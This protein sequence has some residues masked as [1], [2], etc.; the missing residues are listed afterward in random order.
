MAKFYDHIDPKVHA[1]IDRQHIFFTA[2]AAEGS[3][4]N[5]SPKGLDGFRVLDTKTVAY[6]DW[7]GS[8]NETAAHIRADGRL[9]IMMCAF[10]GPPNILRLYGRGR[11]LP[12]SSDAFREMIDSSFD[13]EE[14]ASARQ[15]IVLDVESVQTSC[16]FGVP[17]YDYQGERASLARWAE[18]ASDLPGYRAGNNLETIDGIPTGH[19]E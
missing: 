2:T 8:G 14:P 6:L 9:T 4:I 1:F 18:A 12:K 15:I 17:V 16:G 3:R 5:L 19:I 11:V 7:T 13:G 10:D